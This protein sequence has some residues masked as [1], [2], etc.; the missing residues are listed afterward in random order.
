[1]NIDQ[2]IVNEGKQ[3]YLRLCNEYGID[4]NPA[5][6]DKSI[7][8]LKQTDPAKAYEFQRKFEK[9]QYLLVHFV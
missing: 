1:M 2:Q 4:A 6:I 9:L 3:V 5:N 8:E 7:E